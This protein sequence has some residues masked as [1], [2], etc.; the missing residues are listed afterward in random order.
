MK[1]KVL[2]PNIRKGQ[3]ETETKLDLQLIVTQL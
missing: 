3:K 2:R 1:I